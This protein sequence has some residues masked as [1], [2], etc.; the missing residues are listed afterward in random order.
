MTVES[1]YVIAITTLSDWWNNRIELC[2][3]ERLAG[4]DLYCKK[5]TQRTA[6]FDLNQLE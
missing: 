3:C 6:Y 4:D 2:N 5:K 1:N